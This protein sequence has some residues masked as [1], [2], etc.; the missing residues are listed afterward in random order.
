M[1]VTELS[2]EYAKLLKGHEVRR[3]QSLFLDVFW[4]QANQ[5][6]APELALDP[7]GDEMV[8][9]NVDVG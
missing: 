7:A 4:L 2:E 1:A 9:A 3:R 5:P 6:R 8:S